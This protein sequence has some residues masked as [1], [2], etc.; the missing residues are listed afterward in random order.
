MPSLHQILFFAAAFILLVRLVLV[1]PEQRF[2]QQLLSA[3]TQWSS[4]GTAHLFDVRQGIL[5][6]FY[7][8]SLRWQQ[9][10]N[11][12]FRKRCAKWLVTDLILLVG[13]LGILVTLGVLYR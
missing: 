9:L 13:F 5:W 8:L 6:Q 10:E 4:L 3:G 2:S 1:G 12:V 7:L 11:P